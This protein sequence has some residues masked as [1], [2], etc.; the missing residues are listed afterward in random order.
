[1]IKYIIIL[2]GHA[3]RLAVGLQYAATVAIRKNNVVADATRKLPP[4]AIQ[5]RT[6]A[7]LSHPFN[8]ALRIMLLF[9]K[10]SR[11]YGDNA[12]WNTNCKHTERTT[13]ATDLFRPDDA[14]AEVVD[15]LSFPQQDDINVP[16]DEQ[17]HHA[18]HEAAQEPSC[19]AYGYNGYNVSFVF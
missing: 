19:K 15:G 18:A 11:I 14:P 1:M 10:L 3:S 4:T 16:I 8:H 5:D 13:N 6:L 17:Q 2:A 7:S 12:N 9:G